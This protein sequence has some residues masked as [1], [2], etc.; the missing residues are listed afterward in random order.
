[1]GVCAE[2]VCLCVCMHMCVCVCVRTCVFVCVYARVF[3]CVC[4]SVCVCFSVCVCV[5]MDAGPA[6]PGSVRF[7]GAE[8]KIG[9]ESPNP[10]HL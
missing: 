10:G 3:L 8:I 9:C 1:M 7:S 6:E 4:V 5:H 2:H